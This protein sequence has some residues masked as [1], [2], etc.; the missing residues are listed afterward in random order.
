MRPSRMAWP[1]HRSAN[2]FFRVNTPLEINGHLMSRIE[3]EAARLGISTSEAV[4][5]ALRLFLRSAAETKEPP[6][7]PT[8]HGGELLIDI[9]DR[10]KLYDLFDE[11]KPPL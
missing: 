9:C 8:F 4:E 6:P 11:E 1:W 10:E 2:K 7:L 5:S 3:Q